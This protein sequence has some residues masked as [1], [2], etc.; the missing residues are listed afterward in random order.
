LRGEIQ[1]HYRN[2]LTNGGATTHYQFQYD[3]SL[4]G[5][6]EPTRTN[7]VIAAAEADFNQMT[8]WFGG[9]ALD[10]TFLITVNVTQNGASVAATSP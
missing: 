6:L 1:W 7:Q 8:G 9:I 2:G 5:G 10:V 4:V 3:D